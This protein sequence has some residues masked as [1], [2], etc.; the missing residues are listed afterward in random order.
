MN[1]LLSSFVKNVIVV[2]LFTTC[3]STFL[4]SQDIALGESLY[5]ANCASCHYLGPEEKK[6]IGPGLNDEIFEEHTIE[7]LYKW[8]RNSAE[9]IESGDKVA[10]ELYEEYNKAVMT[11]FPHF[12]NQDI[13]NIL[14][15]IRVGPP[16]V[17]ASNE[18]V[19]TSI[20][21]SESNTS[22]YIIL[23]ILLFNI[24]LLVHVKNT[25]KN[26]ASVERTNFFASV[27]YWLKANPSVIVFASILIVFSGMKGCWNT[28]STIG[29]AQN[30]QPEQPIAFSHKIHSG[31]N[32]ID[33]NY[34][35][36]TARSSKHAGI[37]SVNVCMNC[38]T[39]INEGAITGKEEINKIYEAVGFD[40]NTRT[41][42]P[43]YDQKP[44]EWVRIHNLPDLAYFNHSQHVNVAGL[45][46]QT[47][48]GPVEEMEE[49]YQYSKLT[50][51][52][53]V[54]CHRETEI[55]TDN[56]YYHDLHK[57]WIDKYHGE[58]VTVDMIGGRECAK[59]HY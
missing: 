49:V 28:L 1:S 35:H 55:D 47:C 10:N 51:G 50:M 45:E 27:F 15:Y 53:C 26:A 11:A 2:F 8:I 20:E 9:L 52:W 21:G 19:T 40:P 6:L 41:Y 57:E 43:N 44:V 3:L 39:Y 14:E 56:P 42:I 38:H 24:I 32:G 33:C 34:C 13:D 54:N 7:W 4:Y 29:V 46:C 59:C 31:D 37:P 18:Q 23:S 16:E 5:K 36:H 25:L 58:E 22:L 17:T 12:S 30:Y 48:H